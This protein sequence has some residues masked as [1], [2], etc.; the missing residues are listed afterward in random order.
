MKSFYSLLV[1]MCLFTSAQAVLADTGVTE[2]NAKTFD[3]YL[4]DSKLPVLVEFGTAWCG[5]CQKQ[6]PLLVSAA[7]TYQTRVN[8][9]RIDCDE[10]AAVCTKYNI[11]GYPTLV[12]VKKQ[13]TGVLE[14][15]RNEGYLNTQELA[16]FIEANTK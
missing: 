4:S 12:V 6:Y 3:Q 8:I 15:A 2:L 11:R 5:W 10:N 16:A 1:A 14:A 13:G 9:A 7:T